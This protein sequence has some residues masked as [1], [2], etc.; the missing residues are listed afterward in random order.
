MFVFCFPLRVLSFP[1]VIVAP[2]RVNDS[3][4]YVKIK[5]VLFIK[6]QYFT[7]AYRQKHSHSVSSGL[8]HIH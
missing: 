1:K 7:L 4:L 5:Y 3:E 2:Q 6:W 8:T